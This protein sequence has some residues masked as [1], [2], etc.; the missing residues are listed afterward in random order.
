MIRDLTRIAVILTALILT[1]CTEEEVVIET[2]AQ[3]MAVPV[4][5][6]VRHQM[7]SEK[8][9]QTFTID[10]A[11]PFAPSDQPMPVVYVTDGGTMFPLVAN[12]A[13]LLQ[14]GYEL[15]P[16]IVVGI[17]YPAT[18]PAEV[19][20]LR[21]RELTPT[22]DEEFVAEA[23]AGPFPLPEGVLPGGA[24]AFLDFIEKQVKP[25]I[26]ANYPV[27]D[28]ETLVGD[29]LGG[30][31]ALYALFN[32]TGDYDRYLAGSPSI[33]WDDAMLFEEE[34]GY[35]TDN[36]DMNVDL[37]LSVGGLE[38]VV[39]PNES[40]MVSNTVEMGKRLS[41]RSYPNL[42]LTEHVFDGETHL[43]V[44]PATFSRGLRALFAADVETLR[45]ELAQAA[46][47]E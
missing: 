1:G 10:V 36:E 8:I 40:R 2:G 22:M 35:A 38:E 5:G 31:F 32:R 43:S 13:R 33:W 16:M 28:N 9:G 30:L 20:A 19:L 26:R 34:T 39:D 41:A 7:Y 17:G 15:P 37:F 14:L 12:S 42:R 47:A 24:D 45:A 21:T 23:A 25:M 44:I 6:S 4:S 11:L 29:S 46:Q 27:T 18:S 3:P